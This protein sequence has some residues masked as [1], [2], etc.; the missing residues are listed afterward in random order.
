MNG[1]V[2][3]IEWG[4]QC[5]N[6][7]NRCS[8]GTIRSTVCRRPHAVDGKARTIAGSERENRVSTRRVGAVAGA[9]HGM[10]VQGEVGLYLCDARPYP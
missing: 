1:P 10:A 4:H 2:F 8:C 6:L 7:T 9:W 3:R 5:A